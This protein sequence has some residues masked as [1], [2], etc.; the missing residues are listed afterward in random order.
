MPQVPRSI[1]TGNELP[2][3][4][5]Q[6]YVVAPPPVISV[7]PNQLEQVMFM[8]RALDNLGGAMQSYG[9]IEAQRQAVAEDEAKKNAVMLQGLGAQ[10]AEAQLADVAAW[11][12]SRYDP[13]YAY[14]MPP[15][16]MD[17]ADYP[18][19][20]QRISAQLSGMNDSAGMGPPAPGSEEIFAGHSKA[21]VSPAVDAAIAYR[22]EVIALNRA[23]QRSMLTAGLIAD[24]TAFTFENAQ[25]RMGAELTEAE[26]G[27][28][29]LGAADASMNLG[30][31]EGASTLLARVDGLQEKDPIAYS[32]AMERYKKAT[33]EKQAQERT[34]IIA[35]M[36][37]GNSAVTTTEAAAGGT[38]LAQIVGFTYHTM[39]GWKESDT[40]DTIHQ[41]EDIVL[42]ANIGTTQK[43][44]F[45]TEFVSMS[46]FSYPETLLGPLTASDA[47]RVEALDTL[48]QQI[49][50]G[51]P[52][53]DTQWKVGHRQALPASHPV[54]RKAYE[55]ISQLQEQTENQHKADAKINDDAIGRVVDAVAARV[56]GGPDAL[57][58]TALGA[59][60]DEEGKKAGVVV[61]QG[62]RNAMMKG[63]NPI[64]L[65]QHAALLVD[66]EEATTL[67]TL[68]A[69]KD[70]IK[71]NLGIL[72]GPQYFSLTEKIA[73]RTETA[74]VAT[75][76][77][78]TRS[79]IRS[80]YIAKATQGRKQ[81]ILNRG[82]EDLLT[83][84]E[85]L[86]LAKLEI[87]FDK[88][89]ATWLEDPARGDLV[90]DKAKLK[91]EAAA[92]IEENLA[93]PS[94]ITSFMPP[95]TTP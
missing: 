13:K 73:A 68:L 49:A 17:V 62:V 93:I 14:L 60:M 37:G 27:K 69:A 29:L 8:L 35:G 71:A 7:V 4:P 70:N 91:A 2:P 54:M 39:D 25:H 95:K 59:M 47:D 12:D 64:N 76:F 56:A 9:K 1:L 78:R 15:Q 6:G 87:A 45:F 3:Q 94:W 32:Q 44:A 81:T 48:T 57:N 22:S 58:P 88:T 86:G 55:Y 65:A 42:N 20:Y 82:A 53:T 61:P 16:G 30:K 18:E 72:T 92:M 89:L 43:L 46:G 23:N 66:L 67:P 75:A 33:I 26:Y 50:A 51:E 21:F 63:E 84:E 10:R 52:I 90:L 83:M 19:Y 77:D 36:L 85:A 24:P 38:R 31:H 80:A 34:G 74:T 41:M 40:T 11:K 5:Q 28:I 79:N